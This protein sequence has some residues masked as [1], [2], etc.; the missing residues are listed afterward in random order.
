MN[1]LYVDRGSYTADINN[2]SEPSWYVDIVNVQRTNLPSPSKPKAFEGVDQARPDAAVGPAAAEPTQAAEPKT[3]RRTPKHKRALSPEQEDVDEPKPEP[4]TPAMKAKSS[5]TVEHAGQVSQLPATPE[6]P[7]NSAA[8]IGCRS[9]ELPDE[10]IIKLLVPKPGKKGGEQV[11]IAL[12]VPL[13]IS[14]SA[15]IEQL[16][17]GLPRR[18]RTW[19]PIL[20][21]I[22]QYDNNQLRLG[23]KDIDEAS[24][25]PIFLAE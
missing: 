25:N 12:V 20:R 4:A 8:A 10:I 7:R 15:L 5:S 16:D 9:F 24:F 1:A 11:I 19:I 6:V 18:P 17:K 3:P 23:R 2:W 21:I 22:Q 14:H 13:D